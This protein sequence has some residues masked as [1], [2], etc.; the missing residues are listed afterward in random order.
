MTDTEGQ[1]IPDWLDVIPT[2][3]LGIDPISVDW[4]R[5]GRVLRATI[6][7]NEE[8]KGPWVLRVEVA[9]QYGVPLGRDFVEIV[10]DKSKVV[11]VAEVKQ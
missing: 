3:T 11:R 2:V 8:K 5:E 9:D 4:K 1:P 7:P 10:E 6:P